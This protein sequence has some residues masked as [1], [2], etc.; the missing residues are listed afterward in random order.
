MKPEVIRFDPTDDLETFRLEARPTL[1]VR[2]REFRRLLKKD[3]QHTWNGRRDGQYMKIRL[4]ISREDG[5][6]SNQ[7]QQRGWSFGRPR[8]WQL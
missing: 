7:R 8:D 5:P 1:A 4:S 2:D 3:T 6:K